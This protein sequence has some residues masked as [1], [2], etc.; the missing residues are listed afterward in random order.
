MA[1][2]QCNKCGMKGLSWDKDSFEKTGR[3]KLIPHKTN[4]GEWCG[5]N[6]KKKP[7]YKSNSILCE[8]CEGTSFGLCRGEEDYER[9]KKIYHPNNEVLTELDW[10]MKQTPNKIPHENWSCDPHY[11]TYVK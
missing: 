5:D 10:H 7:Q 1:D 2:K 4:V 9:H 11:S 8:L 6:F 3:W